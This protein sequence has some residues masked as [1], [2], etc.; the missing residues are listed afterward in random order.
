MTGAIYSAAEISDAT[1]NL[2]PTRQV[3][4]VGPTQ[5]AQF[6]AEANRLILS[7]L[8]QNLELTKMNLLQEQPLI[9]LVDEP[10]YPL[11]V[12]RVGKGKSIIIG[13]FLIGFLTLLFL[14][15]QKWWRDI[16]AEV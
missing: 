9:Q 5:E 1:P 3:Q 13:G 2:N 7:Q 11:K 15:V 4:R 14:I 6:L 16:I 12:D 8:L 10:V